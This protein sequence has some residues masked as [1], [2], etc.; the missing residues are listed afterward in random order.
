MTAHLHP[1]SFAEAADLLAADPAAVVLA[2]GTGLQPALTAAVVPPSALVHLD[3]IEEARTVRRHDGVLTVG[4]LVPVAAPELAPWWGAGGPAW[5]ATPA[6]R[7]RATVAGNLVSGLGPRELGPM[8]VATGALAE[9]WSGRERRSVPVADLLAHGIGRGVVAGVAL[10]VPDRVTHQRL[11]VRDRLSRVELGL[12][13]ARGP[14][15][16]AA[17]TLGVGAPAAPVPW[18]GDALDRPDGAP[19]LV[20]AVVRAAEAGGAADEAVAVLA[21]LA[22]RAHTELHDDSTREAVG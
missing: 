9:V 19:G 21:G 3:R 10:R 7:R 1:R 20:A 8:A 22:R 16:G 6:V 17:L 12:Y 11:S 4:A 15:C 14:G 2:G 18:L 5:F 13:A